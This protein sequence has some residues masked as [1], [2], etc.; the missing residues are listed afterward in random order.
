MVHQEAEEDHKK[1]NAISGKEM[2]FT[3][4]LAYLKW[5]TESRDL[6]LWGLPR[7]VSYTM[8]AN[9]PGPYKCMK[10]LL[11]LPLWPSIPSVW[12]GNRHPVCA[13]GT[14]VLSLTGAQ[15]LPSGVNMGLG[16]SLC[17][18][19]KLSVSFA[20]W[21]DAPPKLV[22]TPVP[23]TAA[24]FHWSW[25]VAKEWLHSLDRWTGE[26][27]RLKST[28]SSTEQAKSIC[29]KRRATAHKLGTTAHHFQNDLVC[30]QFCLLWQALLFPLPPPPSFSLTPI[31]PSYFRFQ[32]PHKRRSPKTIIA[33][34]SIASVE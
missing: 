22:G 17:L 14:S 7:E 5:E 10:Y 25:R 23:E 34:T 29:C 19:L 18:S 1:S 24:S 28:I 2:L 31:V 15:P 11:A 8:K 6:I 9:K 33:Q 16:C 4:V 13:Q 20:Y 12:V 3:F 32:V 21:V 26:T 30:L 27:E